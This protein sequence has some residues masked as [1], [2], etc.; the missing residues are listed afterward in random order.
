[1]TDNERTHDMTETTETTEFR[2]DF[3]VTPD[4]EWRD[5][6]VQMHSAKACTDYIAGSPWDDECYRAV[7]REVTKTVTATPWVPLTEGAA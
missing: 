6:G 1:M 3:R 7:T 4:V 2:L 5:V